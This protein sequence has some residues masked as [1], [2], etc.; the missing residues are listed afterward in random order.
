MSKILVLLFVLLPSSSLLFAITEETEM[1]LKVEQNYAS[2]NYLR[3]LETCKEFIKEFPLSDLV[4]D[5][6]Y[7]TGVCL[8]RLERYSEALDLFNTIQKRYRSTKYRE[9]ISFWAGIS[10]YFLG[11]YAQ[12][13]NVLDVFLGHNAD[14]K[15]NVQAILYKSLSEIALASYS[16]A[17]VT[18]NEI[19]TEH[20][21]SAQIYYA[22]ALLSYV[23]LQENQYGE[24]LKL[25]K[26][27]NAAAFPIKWRERF[28]LYLAEAFWE[29][30]ETNEAIRMYSE[31][32]IA[33]QEVALVAFRRL[34][35][36]AQQE[37]DFSQMEL[38]IQT[39]E[40][41]FATSP[42]L[43][44]DFWLH[45]GVETYNKG[46]FDL[47]EYFLSKVWNLRKKNALD[48]IAPI[49]LAEI[50]ITENELEKATDILIEYL[51]L[52]GSEFSLILMRLGD[53][54]LMRDDYLKASEYYRELMEKN[55]AAPE[56]GEAGYLLAYTYY[57]LGEMDQSLQVLNRILNKIQRDR[58][59]TDA[60]K[61]KAVI[62]KKQR[63]YI[64][65]S[66][67]FR[68]YVSFNEDDLDAHVELLKV[69][70]VLKRY[71]EVIEATSELQAV[72]PL[73][74]QNEP[75]MFVLT[76]YLRGLSLVS[77][78]LYEEA[79][80]TFNLINEES[81]NEADLSII[82]PYVKYYGA[83]SL[84]KLGDYRNA[85]HLF[86][87]I[88]GR[89]S[90]HDLY[91]QVLYMVGWCYFSLGEYVK[92]N[93]YFSQFD[94][95]RDNELA[96][97]A[98]FLQGKSLFNLK[99]YELAGTVFKYLIDE[100]AFSEFVDDAFFEYSNSL[101]RSG[102]TVDAAAGFLE[103]SRKFPHSP[104][105]E[106]ALFRRGEL[107]F[108]N[109]MFIEAKDAF[110]EYRLKFPQGSLID[111]SL[112]WGGLSSYNLGEKY[113][114]V[115]LWEKIIEVYHESP[116]KPDAIHRTAEIYIE[117]GEY[118]KAFKLYTDLITAY[119]KEAESLNAKEKTEKLRYLILGLSEQEAQLT[120]IISREGG[121]E[122]KRGRKAL[123]ELASLYIVEDDVKIDLAYQM[124]T[125]VLKRGDAE[126]TGKAQFLIG[127]YFHRKGEVER[128][129]NEFLKVAL[130]QP[131]DQDLIAV[132][133]Y[134][135]AEM[136]K[137][138]GKETEL[139]ELVDRLEKS[140]PSSRWVLEGK[141]LLDNGGD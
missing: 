22:V 36:A 101:A 131:Q 98:F 127:E 91:V 8:F 11:E 88:L 99:E 46:N 17:R 94:L 83:W 67:A 97:K 120:A 135:A 93:D 39:A 5:V 18:L 130:L 69:L 86:S 123:I 82:V 16:E 126:S 50:Y 133:I 121:A 96:P 136:M 87:D 68:D 52:G 21:N 92:S 119:P 78:K 47:S 38:L 105:R 113:A 76:M 44:K 15:L 30:Q 95:F 84:Y 108:A 26:R 81:A 73:L 112:Y 60:I 109:D 107:Y 79:N 85:I 37:E 137:I 75:Y 25:A 45:T 111:A 104:L 138:A 64:G 63:N 100:Y 58:Y 59:Y 42:Q 3:A 28:L 57:R 7:R 2:K 33:S 40:S 116:F 23:L 43:L 139:V 61:L 13:V 66:Q 48:H 29:K 124:L 56:Y 27:F 122:T 140:F 90:E 74:V 10:L 35:L 19:V 51:S 115:L 77:K 55:P 65:A 103:L 129:G 24:I 141:K 114:A 71:D 41:R 6:Q 118:N 34:F 14:A 128:A 62:M 89:F 4:P 125:E 1:Y 9:F 12:A 20:T 106:E 132:S 31:L 72:D 134:R 117:D 70:F 54:Y 110:F 80:R 49:Y 102:D 53:I 32:L